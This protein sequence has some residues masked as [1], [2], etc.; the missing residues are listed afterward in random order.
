MAEALN[1]IA[2]ASTT[3]CMLI[4]ILNGLMNLM[5][6]LT[7]GYRALKGFVMYLA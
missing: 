6:I 5:K 4:Y 7:L 1:G 3:T 2:Q